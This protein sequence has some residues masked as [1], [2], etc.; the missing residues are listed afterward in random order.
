MG[1]DHS[2]IDEQFR[3]RRFD[4]DDSGTFERDLVFVIM[5]FSDDMNGAYEAIRD[6]CKKFGLTAKR[7][8]EGV[9]SAIILREI[10]DYIERAELLICDLTH[11]RPN[12]YY[13]LGYAHG[14]GN[15]SADILLIAR[16]GTVLHFDI[17][18]IRV[19][20]YRDEAHVREIISR[21][22]PRMLERSRQRL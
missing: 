1:R 19:Q 4:P 10:T 12:V 14:V 11:Q 21:N 3:G 18:P 2:Y 8:D 6:Q 5:A 22:I 15:E 17:A 16:E 9:G 20:F 13:E 7:A